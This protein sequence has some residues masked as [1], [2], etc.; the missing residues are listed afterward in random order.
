L[1]GN[2]A[3]AQRLLGWRA[4]TSF[5]ELIT[6]MTLSQKGLKQQAH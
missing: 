4:K 1:I 2:P 5:K 3:K 6:E